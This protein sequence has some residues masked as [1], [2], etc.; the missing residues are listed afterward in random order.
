[1]EW[2]FLRVYGLL[3]T[4]GGVSV[5]TS[6]K[7]TKIYEIQCVLLIKSTHCNKIHVYEVK[8]I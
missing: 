3:I 5:V 2:G 8:I 7:L 4:L 1:M 6:V